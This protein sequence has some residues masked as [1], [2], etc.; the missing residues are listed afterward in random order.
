MSADANTD[1]DRSTPTG[2]DRDRDRDRDQGQAPNVR[3]ALPVL[4]EDQRA[5]LESTDNPRYADEYHLRGGFPHRRAVIQWF[6]RAIIRTFGHIA[7]DY[8]VA[9]QLTY[10]P[11]LG[12][13]VTGP[14]RDRWLHDHGED[15]LS[16]GQARTGRRKY[17]ANTLLPACH[18]AY[19]DLLDVAGEY[20]GEEEGT[21]N[22]RDL[23]PEGQRHVAMRPG[24]QH[25]DDQQHAALAQLW[26]GFPD[27]DA[28]LS[29]VHGLEGPTNGAVRADLAGI[30]ERTPTATA[31]FLAD[32][33]G[34]REARET[35]DDFAVRVLLPAFAEGVRQASAGE[36]AAR[37]RTKLSPIPG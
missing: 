10:G 17:E 11:L 29:W 1:A 18:R 32:A 35:K 36:L 14:E 27:E 33:T 13:L 3:P 7:D 25:L 4:L 23:D 34:A 19:N 26:A 28:L 22:Y 16:P 6:Q 37:Q 8:G 12:V 30:F 21:P 15:T 20:I 9:E 31:L 2:R 24:F 5:L